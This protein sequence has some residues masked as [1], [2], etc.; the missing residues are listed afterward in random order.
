MEISIKKQVSESVLLMND[1][2][3]VRNHDIYRNIDKMQAFGGDNFKEVCSKLEVHGK[4][5]YT[6]CGSGDHPLELVS[7]GFTYIE[8]FDFNLLAKHIL[9]LKI[10]AILILDYDEF[11][12]FSK[13]L[14]LAKDLY[15]KIIPAL[16]SETYEYFDL[17]FFRESKENIYNY[18]FTHK[19]MGYDELIDACKNNFSFYNKKEF[20]LLKEKL[21]KATIVF[22]H[23][24]LFEGSNLKEQCDFIYFSNILFFNSMSI[25]E[26][27]KKILPSYINHLNKDGILVLH[28]LH[29]FIG[30]KKKG[31]HQ[32]ILT[33]S[34]NERDFKELQDVVHSSIIIPSSGF[35]RGMQ[36]DDMILVLKKTKEI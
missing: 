20:Y 10:A 3:Y 23:H 7:Q 16:P 1:W 27:K 31:F 32:D 4:R 14:F 35:G 17:L 15:A 24:N 8:A 22:K 36:E 11:I 29:H 21:V 34:K 5:A 6:V 9:N 13:K 33:Q 28:Y 26:F 19:Y 12:Q 18:L 25:E 30:A 2:D